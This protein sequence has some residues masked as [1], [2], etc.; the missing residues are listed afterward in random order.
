M[1]IKF[2]ANSD[3]EFLSKYLEFYNL[4]VVEEQR[5]NPSEIALIVEFATLPPKFEY[6]RFSSLAKSKVIESAALDS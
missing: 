6:Q 5:L 1:T 4:L 3:K 2:T